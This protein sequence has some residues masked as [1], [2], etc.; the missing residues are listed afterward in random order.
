MFHCNAMASLLTTRFVLLVI[1]C[2][3]VRGKFVKIENLHLN[4]VNEDTKNNWDTGDV[5]LQLQKATMP[6]TNRTTML[7]GY[8]FGGAGGSAAG[9]GAKLLQSVN[10]N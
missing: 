3:I 6:S 8:R 4:E 9:D 5:P 1:W 7:R 10:G 2:E